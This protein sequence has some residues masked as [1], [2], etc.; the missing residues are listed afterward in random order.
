MVFLASLL[1][2]KVD[3]DPSQFGGEGSDFRAPSTSEVLSAYASEAYFGTGTAAAD[4]STLK[5]QQAKDSGAPITEEQYKESAYY[6]PEISYSRDMTEEAAKELAIFSD[7]RKKNAEII[8]SAS[9]SQDVAGVI[10]GFVAGVSEP[11][12]VALGVVTSAVL[13][14]IAGWIAPAASSLRKVI[15]LKKIA[16]NYGAKAAIG[17]VEGM[18]GA[19]IA[20]PSNRYSAKILQQD[21]TAA[22]SILNISL[23]AAFGAGFNVAPSFIADKWRRHKA[24]T[25]EIVAHEMDVAS[26]QILD[27]QVT[28]V[29]HVELSKLQSDLSTISKRIVT[30]V[31]EKQ[32]D[33]VPLLKEYVSDN[34]DRIAAYDGGKDLVRVVDRIAAYEKNI[35]E[36][37]MQLAESEAFSK[38]T[39]TQALDPETTARIESIDL[40]LSAKGL[41][42]KKRD[43][44]LREKA[45]LE[46]GGGAFPPEQLGMLDALKQSEASKAKALEVKIKGQSDLLVKKQRE[47]RRLTREA[48]G[49]ARTASQDVGATIRQS[50]LESN[51][52]ENN[53]LYDEAGINALEERNAE[54]LGSQ[55]TPEKEL[56]KLMERLSVMKREGAIT[57]EEAAM[58][59][60]YTGAIKES[61]MKSAYDSLLTCMTGA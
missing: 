8:S 40:E 6:R 32:A 30:E 51:S 9:L 7:K 26:S 10:T 61:D 44:L 1:S 25:P 55:Q 31:P 57:E 49:Y 19:A 38:L 5:V 53:I 23:S 35:G 12:N 46:E 45:M 50:V 16:G 29:D 17:G 58:L 41:R 47:L 2:P 43:E 60:D 11:K 36:L 13:T 24:A 4:F 18:V 48:V 56:A 15:A 22:D 52:V 28:S 42:A 20:E 54:L 27:G 59:S 3:T 34:R 14:P 33:L 21:Y 39:P 37:R